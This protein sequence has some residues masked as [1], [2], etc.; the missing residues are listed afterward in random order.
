[1]TRV[2]NKT[3]GPILVQIETTPTLDPDLRA[4][5]ERIQ[6]DVNYALALSAGNTAICIPL[7]RIEHAAKRIIDIHYGI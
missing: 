3:I 1:M 2:T 4:T 5:I 7:S 6:A